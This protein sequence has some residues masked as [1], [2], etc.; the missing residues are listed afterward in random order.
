[1]ETDFYFTELPVTWHDVVTIVR[2]LTNAS[3]DRI[4]EVYAELSE[5]PLSESIEANFQLTEDRPDHL[6]SNWRE[7]LYVLV[8]LTS[9]EIVVETGI[10]DGLSASY[11]LAALD[12]NDRGQLTSIDVNDPE[13]L[14]TDLED[15]DAG[16]VVPDHLRP[17]WDRRFGDSK[18]ILPEVVVE[19]DVDFFIHDSLHEYDH[20]R[21]EYE[22][23]VPAMSEG[24]VF[25][26]DNVFFSTAFEE[27]AAT[28]LSNTMYWRNTKIDAE[29][30]GLQMDD[31]LGL[32]LVSH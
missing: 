32:G 2:P 1:M 13:V 31:R 29:F 6:H 25:V 5:L 26:S 7:F 8:R 18:D 14:P 27:F 11:I 10:Y 12:Q 22:T 4:R 17:R 19:Y 21:F 16:W 20:M 23:V 9:P 15:P 3:D 28:H 30:N 24:D